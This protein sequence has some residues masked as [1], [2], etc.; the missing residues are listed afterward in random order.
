MGRQHRRGFTLIELLVVIAVIAVLM[1][2]LLPAVQTAREAARRTQ[3]KNNLKQMGLA[4]HNHHST[5]GWFP[6]AHTAGPAGVTYGF[7]HPLPSDDQYWFSWLAR[8]LP[9]VEQ[10]SLYEEIDWK[11]WAWTNPPDGLSAG[12]YI[13]DRSMTLYQCPSFSGDR[14]PLIYDI[15]PAVGFA[16]THYLGINGTDQCEFDGM[17]QVNQ[18]VRFGDVADGTS[19]T[20]LVGERPPDYYRYWGWWFAGSGPDP[21]F[22]AIVVV[23]GTAEWIAVDGKCAPLGT[24]SYYQPGNDQCDD[25][26]S[27][28]GTDK[29]SWH[30][31]SEHQ[32]G[33]YFLFADGSVRF[34]SYE[35]G[36]D[37]FRK[38]GTR[39]GGEV[40][41]D[42]F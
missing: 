4:L 35:I 14:E 41:D 38:L 6:P 31:W 30:F 16:H 24:R 1:G 8:L 36:Q 26:G 10:N 3:C 34:I 15:P 5:H 17:L 33:A 25:D 27:G 20:L 29:D 7:N 19:N 21:Y 40:I 42:A 32:G 9:Y 11:A 2:L 13:N 37:V 22:G 39:H 23:L 12:G 18:K 28:M